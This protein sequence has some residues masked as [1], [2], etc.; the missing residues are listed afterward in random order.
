M[1][2]QTGTVPNNRFIQKWV[3]DV[4]AMCQPDSVYWCDGSDQETELLTKVAVQCGDLLHH[5]LVD[6][7]PAGG[8]DDQH[9]VIMPSCPVKRGQGDIDGLLVECGRK[10]IGADLA[11][12]SL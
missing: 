11:G 1:S 4:A 2:N 7:Q 6:A 10:S 12:D 3:K 8:I 9:I 5:R